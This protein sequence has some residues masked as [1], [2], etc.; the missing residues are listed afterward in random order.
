L[1]GSFSGGKLAA[2]EA[3]MSTIVAAL[4]SELKQLQGELARDPRYKRIALIEQL[5]ANY[6]STAL[7]DMVARMPTRGD[8]P[9]DSKEGKAKKE[10]LAM[11][12]SG[13]QPRT[14]LLEALTAKKIMGHEDYPIKSLGKFLG[15]WPEVKSDG[16]GTWSLA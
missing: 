2:G 8:P 12:A 5:L 3:S 4:K 1:T 13:P 14:K 15:R 7:S 9:P 10:V 6:S 11:L 16:K